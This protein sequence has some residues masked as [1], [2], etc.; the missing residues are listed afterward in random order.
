MSYLD[1]HVMHYFVEEM[2][3][4]ALLGSALAGFGKMV[5]AAGKAAG[6]GASN[7]GKVMARAAGGKG[8][9]GVKHVLGGAALGATGLY[10][11]KK[12]LDYARKQY[13]SLK[14]LRPKHNTGIQDLGGM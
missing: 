2:E 14:P 10:A 4:Q 12:G 11:G 1:K 3:K 8:P 9:M 5:A 6:K 7:Y 13:G